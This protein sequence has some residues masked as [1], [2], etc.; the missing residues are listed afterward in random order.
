MD[1]VSFSG[2][3]SATIRDSETRGLLEAKDFTDLY[4]DGV[5]LFQGAAFRQ[6]PEGSFSRLKL[7]KCNLLYG[8]KLVL[9]RPVGDRTKMEKVLVER[10]FFE[11]GD[12]KADMTDKQIAERIDDGADDPAVS[13][14]A[15][16]QNP[17]KSRHYFLSEPLR[18]RR[19]AAPE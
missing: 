3:A 8:M 10:F 12:E 17:Q 18:K 2:D 15:F 11:A 9:H 14:K 16:W 1:A 19:P 7:V 5:D 4:V 6:R 13:V